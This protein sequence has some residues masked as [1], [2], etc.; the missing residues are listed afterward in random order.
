MHSY[1]VYKIVKSQCT[2]LENLYKTVGVTRFSLILINELR[3]GPY[4][5]CSSTSYIELAGLHIA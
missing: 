4:L 3:V 2:L 1:V 5:H